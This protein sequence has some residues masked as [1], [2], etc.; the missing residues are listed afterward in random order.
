M[1]LTGL[2]RGS[3]GGLVQALLGGGMVCRGATGHCSVY[4]SLGVNT[5]GQRGQR[6][7]IPAGHGVKM[8][9]AQTINRPREELYRFWRNFENLPRF[10]EFLQ[11]VKSTGDNRT[12]WVARGPMGV[13]FEWDSEVITDTTNELI[14]W[15]SLPGS[16]VDTAGSVHFTQ[17]PG[18]RGTEVRVVMKYDP[19][20]GKV[21]D[22]IARM[23]GRAPDQQLK[24]DL[25]RFKQLMETGEIPTTRGQASGRGRDQFQHTGDMTM[26]KKLS[27]GLGWFSIGL[28][29][30][31]VLA[32][33]KLAE[34]IGAPDKAAALPVLGMREIA[35]GVGILTNP[36]HPAG[37]SSRVL[38]DMM[39]FA[40][41]GGAM[42]SPN[43]SPA[44]ILGAAAAV[45]GVTALDMLASDLLGRRY[46][47]KDV[48][49][50]SDSPRGRVTGSTGSQ[51]WGRGRRAQ[52]A[53]AAGR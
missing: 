27:Y 39:D 1:A 15:R 25:R 26:G 30:A 42:A 18:N 5:A 33:R 32:P 49:H 35:S 45:A 4:Q 2:S 11:S 37:P 17:A 36:T 16:Q 29:L 3:V 13:S 51:T 8:E 24:E 12:H 38:G 23:F 6:S 48:R 44:R 53:A 21:G 43:A 9:V 19:P 41:L 31:E 28:G 40:F 22:L 50:P 34:M 7:S 47:Q 52:P 14:G 20:G 10:M 46:D